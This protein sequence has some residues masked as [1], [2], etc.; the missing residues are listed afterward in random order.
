MPRTKGALNKH[1]K[2]E[3]KYIV[4]FKNPFEKTESTMEFPTVISISEY[5]TEHG[6]EITRAGISKHLTGKTSSPFFSFHYA[7]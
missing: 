4:T 1:N 5:F 3:T 6:V 2:I 7:V